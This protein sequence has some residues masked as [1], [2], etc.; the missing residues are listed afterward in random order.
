MTAALAA[1]LSFAPLPARG[2][3][4]GSAGEGDDDSQCRRQREAALISGE[5]VVCAERERQDEFRIRSREQAQS[6][7]AA[8]TMDSGLGRKPDFAPPPCKPGLLTFCPKFGG[9]PPRVSL[10]RRGR[11]GGAPG[12]RQARGWACR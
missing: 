4:A 6:A 11:A 7:Y 10:W 1:S 8:A 2:Q 9:A 3:P 5:I 12:R